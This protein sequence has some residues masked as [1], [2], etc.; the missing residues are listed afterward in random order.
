MDRLT[1]KTKTSIQR[2]IS[3]PEVK[4]I[5]P[6]LK[7]NSDSKTP[8]IIKKIQAI[9]SY[10]FIATKYKFKS[11]Q[12]KLHLLDSFKHLIIMRIVIYFAFFNHIIPPHDVEFSLVVSLFD[13]R[14]CKQMIDLLHHIELLG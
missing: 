4:D 10:Y 6:R 11:E 13:I 5:F 8:P 2:N 3:L 12:A 9:C 7:E 1:E 14:K